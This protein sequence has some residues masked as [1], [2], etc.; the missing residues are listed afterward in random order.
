MQRRRVRRARADRGREAADRRDRP[1]QADARR[2]RPLASARRGD[3]HPAQPRVVSI[4]QAT[5]LGTVYTPDEIAR[6]RRAAHEHGMLLHVDGA[7]LAN[8]AASLGLALRA[9]TTDAGVDV[10]SFGGDEERPA[11]RR[12][13][14]LPAPRAR[15]TASSSCA[16]SGCS[17]P[18]RCASSP[19]SSRRCSAA[20]CGGAPPSTPTRWRAGWATRS[21]AIDGVELA[22]PVE[23]NGVFATLPA[24]RST[25]CSQR[26]PASTLLRLGR[27]RGDGP[28]DVLLG[29]DRGGRRRLRVER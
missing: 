29:H 3:E 27:G 25:A 23:A 28:L 22:H 18:R 17:S 2:R 8:A 15:A 26:F 21:R 20:T 11:G 12:G 5:E 4:T 1:R 14:R 24:R 16:S 19:P 7:R 10:L 6:A 9:L 13:G